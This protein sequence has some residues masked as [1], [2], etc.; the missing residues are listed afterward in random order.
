MFALKYFPILKFV[1]KL[2]MSAIKKY[3]KILKII[4]KIKKLVPIK[5][6]YLIF[7]ENNTN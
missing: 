1:L 5:N 4:K 2:K 7:K 6:K 3:D